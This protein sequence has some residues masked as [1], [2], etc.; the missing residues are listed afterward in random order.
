MVAATA[1]IAAAGNR[2]GGAVAT[3]DAA[4]VGDAPVTDGAITEVA[5]EVA[6]EVAV[7]VAAEVVAQVAETSALPRTRGPQASHP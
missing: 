2:S 3:E 6:A 5:A 7:D 4:P 1:V